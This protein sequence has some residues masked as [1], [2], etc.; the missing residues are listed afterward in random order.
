MLANAANAPAASPAPSG[1]ACPQT[2]PS[3]VKAAEPVYPSA[4]MKFVQSPISVQ[5]MVMV[6]ATGSVSSAAV[7]QSSGYADADAAALNAAMASTYKPG[8]V[9]CKPAKGLYLFNA[10]FAPH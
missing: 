5:V 6:G 4:T 7:A 1:S 3:V 8:T 2:Q 9:D 10:S